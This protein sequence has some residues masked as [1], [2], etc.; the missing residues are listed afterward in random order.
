MPGRLPDLN[1]RMEGR[2]GAADPGDRDRSVDRHK[3]RTGE[4]EQGVVELFD[5]RQSLT[6]RKPR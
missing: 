1:W 5:R 6:S 3:G 2:G 4:G